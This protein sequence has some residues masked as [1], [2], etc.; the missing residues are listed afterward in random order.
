MLV[1]LHQT[2]LHL[3][4]PIHLQVITA[5]HDSTIRCWDLIAG[6]ASSILT[7]HKKSVRDIGIHPTEYTFYSG[8]ADN[9]KV[10]K[11]PEGNFMRNI[12]GHNAI[13]NT[14]AINRDNV[15]VSG[16]DNGSMYFWDWKTGYNFQQITAVAQP[17]SLDS[18]NSI[19]AMG[20][21]MTGS[22]LITCEGDKSIKIYKE[23]LMLS[24][25]ERTIDSNNF[26][27]T[28]KTN[29]LCARFSCPPAFSLSGRGGERGNSPHQLQTSQ[30]AKAILI[31]VAHH[32]V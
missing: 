32:T 17:G 24:R 9:I 26:P 4:F 6:K 7:N 3:G 29:R 12:S 20:F 2:F 10:W 22:R 23:V 25:N 27:S 5:S 30:K 1:P 11:C 15:L 18:E 14:M 19:L 21:D 28:S 13:I 31:A 16:A 8:S